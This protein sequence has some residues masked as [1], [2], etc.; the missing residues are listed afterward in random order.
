MATTKLNPAYMSMKGNIGK[1]IFYNRKGKQCIRSYCIPR[2]P[3]TPAQKAVRRNFAEAVKAWQMLPL[4]EKEAYNR[5]A[6]KKPLTGYNLFTSEF[7]REK[8]SSAQMS[9]HFSQAVTVHPD[10]PQLRSCAI[11]APFHIVNSFDTAYIPGF[12]SG[13]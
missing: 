4:S 13:G 6:R 8:Y 3:N 2:N 12:T 11:S 10:S 9:A 7:L 5:R 1:L